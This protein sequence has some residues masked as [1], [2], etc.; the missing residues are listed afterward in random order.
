MTNLKLVEPEPKKMDWRIERINYFLDTYLLATGRRCP[1]GYS[2]LMGRMTNA[3]VA[4][5]SF[6]NEETGEIEFDIPDIEDW[7][8]EVDGFFKDKWA[9][10]NLKFHFG[11]FVKSYGKYS[12]IKPKT[13]V[14]QSNLE[15][16]KR[17]MGK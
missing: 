14:S 2:S 17:K 11:Y 10:D 5:H 1:L 3:W 6:T 16:W 13:T 7:K 4:N 9:R 15:E 8:S 12:E